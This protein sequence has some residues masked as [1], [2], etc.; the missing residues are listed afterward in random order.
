MGPNQSSGRSFYLKFSSKGDSHH[1]MWFSKMAVYPY[2]C[3]FFFIALMKW[4]F[5]GPLWKNREQV[6]W[7]YISPSW[8]S[9]LLKHLT[10]ILYQDSFSISTSFTVGH[11][12]GLSS[13]SPPSS[14]LGLDPWVPARTF[15][16]SLFLFITPI[17]PYPSYVTLQNFHD[18][19][20]H[21]AYAFLQVYISWFLHCESNFLPEKELLSPYQALL[22]LSP[23]LSQSIMSENNSDT[24]TC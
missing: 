21:T 20:S 19:S 5:S 9:C 22:W 11:H 17:Q 18:P 15:T 12:W 1:T 16:I 14:M 2:Q 3:I 24:T 4:L 6:L 8:Y 10:S 23:T 7:L 13:R